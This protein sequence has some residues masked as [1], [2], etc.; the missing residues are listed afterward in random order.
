MVTRT[1]DGILTSGQADSMAD[2]FKFAYMVKAGVARA[3]GK[4]AKAADRA[5]K[6]AA[7]K[8]VRASVSRWERT[9]TVEGDTF[10]YT[11]AKSATKT[12]RSS[13]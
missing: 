9:G 11:D 5:A 6:K 2:E 7:S 8:Q 10:T 12:P 1:Q 3:R 4:V 13:T